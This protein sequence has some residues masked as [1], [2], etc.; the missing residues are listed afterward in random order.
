MVNART[1]QIVSRYDDIDSGDEIS[2]QRAGESQLNIEAF[3]TASVGDISRVQFDFNGHV[4]FRNESFFPYALFGDHGGDF[5]GVPLSPGQQ[6][7]DVT[8]YVGDRPA[9]RRSVNFSI[10]Q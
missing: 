7:L 4:R 8:V 10:V 5:I 9:L 3:V 1:N 2:L 6:S